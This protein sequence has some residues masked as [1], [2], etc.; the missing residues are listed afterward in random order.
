MVTE[1]NEAV[2]HLGAGSDYCAFFRDGTRF[3]S[4]VK[5]ESLLEIGFF[6]Q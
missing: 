5:L 3:G 1:E 6:T 4:S 2:S